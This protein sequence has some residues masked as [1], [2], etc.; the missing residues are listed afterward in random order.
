MDDKEL[1]RQ[2]RSH[3]LVLRGAQMDM[4]NGRPDMDAMEEIALASAG[5]DELLLEGADHDQ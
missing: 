3:W 4:L 2:V 5:I 1:L